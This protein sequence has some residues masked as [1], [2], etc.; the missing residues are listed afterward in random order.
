MA[1]AARVR[2]PRQALA[3]LCAAR[4]RHRCYGADSQAALRH[5]D[6][7]IAERRALLAPVRVGARSADAIGASAV[8][9]AG[10]AA[11]RVEKVRRS[12]RTPYNVRDGGWEL[13][14]CGCPRE[15]RAAGGCGETQNAKFVQ[16]PHGTVWWPLRTGARRCRPRGARAVPANRAATLCNDLVLR[17]QGTTP[18]KKKGFLP[19]MNAENADA[20]VTD[21]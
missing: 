13:G 20:P 9:L 3:R 17:F 19:P 11:P 12:G 14:P 4:T 1:A 8:R 2:V 18:I 5:E 15:G 7:F 10:A 21:P 6:E 16:R